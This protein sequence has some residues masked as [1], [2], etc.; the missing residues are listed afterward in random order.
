MTTF[1][2]LYDSTD[3]L[4]VAQGHGVRYT[5]TPNNAKHFTSEFFAQ[6]FAERNECNGFAVKKIT[7]F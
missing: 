5:F 3:K 6:K 1:Y 2:V 7:R 4:F